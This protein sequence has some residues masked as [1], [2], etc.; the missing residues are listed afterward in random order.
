MFRRKEVDGKNSK[1]EEIKNKNP[2]SHSSSWM[3]SWS[4]N[5]QGRKLEASK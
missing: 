4:N 5:C 1:G 3:E 2:T